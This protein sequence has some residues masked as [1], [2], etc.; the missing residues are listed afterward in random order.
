MSIHWNGPKALHHGTN[1]DVAISINAAGTK[2][3]GEQRHCLAIRF[4]NDAEKKIC[5]DSQ[6]IIYGLD[7]RNSRVYFKAASFGAGFKLT[8]N[9]Q[10]ATKTSMVMRATPDNILFW[11]NLEGEY[12]L[13]YD[14][15]EELYYIN[16]YP[17][18]RGK[19]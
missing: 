6:Y 4:Y 9:N 12:F 17:T 16:Y 14:K 13:L 18:K 2:V 3:N 19:A 15:V 8:K 7:V 1:K 5:G 11:W 10:K